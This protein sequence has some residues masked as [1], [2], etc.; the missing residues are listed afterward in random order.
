MSGTPGTLRRLRTAIEK[1]S[2]AE[3]AEL[4]SKT[5][6]GRVFGPT[7]ES[8]PVSLGFHHPALAPAVPWSAPG[9]RPAAWTPASPSTSPA[10]SAWRASTG[11]AS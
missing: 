5:R 9:P 2:A 1:R 8:I 7:V 11:P 6:G 3:A 10:P 4:E